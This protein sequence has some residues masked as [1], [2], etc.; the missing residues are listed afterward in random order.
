M[1][2]KAIQFTLED[3]MNQITADADMESEETI[4][5]NIKY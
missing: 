1:S 4:D 3:T 5:V 2:S